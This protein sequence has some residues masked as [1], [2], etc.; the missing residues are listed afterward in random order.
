[1]LCDRHLH[2]WAAAVASIRRCY[3]LGDHDDQLRI[4]EAS[5]LEMLGD[6]EAAAAAL[7]HDWPKPLQAKAWALRARVWLRTGSIS[8][9][10]MSWLQTQAGQGGEDIQ[11]CWKS[12]GQAL[13][14][15]GRF[16]EAFAAF[17]SGNRLASDV[18]GDGLSAF[19]QAWR[20]VVTP[21]WLQ[22]WPAAGQ[23]LIDPVFLVGFPRS[24]TTLLEQ[25][26]DA[27]PHVSAMEEQPALDRAL[28]QYQ[29]LIQSRPAVRQAVAAAQTL[30]GKLAAILRAMPTL[31][32]H[33]L[34]MLREHYYTVVKAAVTVPA[35]N[36][37]IDKMPLNL[38]HLPFILFLFP[39]ARFLM[40]L[41]DP[42]D[43]VFSGFMQHFGNNPAMNRL[44]SLDRGRS[45][46]QK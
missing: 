34:A 24:G 25:G 37:L 20:D 3:A 13:D 7:N 41:R 11:A 5:L 14:R 12:L 42:A 33:E 30:A 26:L 17:S 9:S 6:A 36:L 27:H 21:E 31:E 44:A 22:Q 35:G 28:E 4:T 10:Q 8:V 38:I 18:P 1:M 39:N 45:S 29:R 32:P 2:D 46:T 19:L 15:L 43:C 40:A 16:D 23:E